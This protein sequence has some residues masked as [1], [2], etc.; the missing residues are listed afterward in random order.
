VPL[1]KDSQTKIY[2]LIPNRIYHIEAKNK[3]GE[4]VHSEYVKPEG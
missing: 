2:N 4:I 3:N 1:N